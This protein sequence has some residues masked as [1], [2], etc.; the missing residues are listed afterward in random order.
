[1]DVYSGIIERMNSKY[2]IHVTR[3]EFVILPLWDC[4]VQNKQGQVRKLYLDA[5]WGKPIDFKNNK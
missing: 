5:V 3:I 4:E 2:G 1:M